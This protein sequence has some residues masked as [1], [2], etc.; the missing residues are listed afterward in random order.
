MKTTINFYRR[1]KK[2]TKFEPLTFKN[3]LI[4]F[5]GLL[6]IMILATAVM[7]MMKNKAVAAADR[8]SEAAEKLESDVA[9]LEALSQGESADPELEKKL[10][11]LRLEEEATEKLSGVIASLK[12]DSAQDFSDL[13]LDLARISDGKVYLSTVSA[14]GS[15]LTVGGVVEKA[16]DAADFAGRLKSSESFRGRKFSGVSVSA[17]KDYP[18]ASEF[19]FTGFDQAAADAAREEARK[20]FEEAHRTDEESEGSE[21]GEA[22]E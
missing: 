15:M 20:A 6:L 7:V 1:E 13:L 12:G 16:S 21:G 14:E 9:Q 10:A 4:L 18:G 2:R 8:Q 19:T 17:S 22:Q 11:K 3:M 5:G